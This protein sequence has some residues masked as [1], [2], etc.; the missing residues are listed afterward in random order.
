MTAITR[1]NPPSVFNGAPHIYNH[2]VRVDNPRSLLFIAGQLSLDSEGN[3][4]GPGNMEE[5]TR[6]C[7]RNIQTIM[8]AEGGTLQDIVSTVVYTTDLREFDRIVKARKEF[9]VANLP[10]S[11]IVEVNHLGRD[12][13]LLIEI[14]ATAAL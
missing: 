6:Q 7:I 13:G 12:A 5:Q 11:T 2:C 9:F 3:V 8:D 10:S 1:N 4:V 14:Q